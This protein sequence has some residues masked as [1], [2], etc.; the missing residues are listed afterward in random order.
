MTFFIEN[1]EVGNIFFCYF[2]TLLIFFWVFLILDFMATY[3][4]FGRF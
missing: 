1:P 3:Q 4:N 2:F